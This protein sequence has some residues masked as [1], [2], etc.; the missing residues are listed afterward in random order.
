MTSFKCR[1]QVLG[2]HV[3]VQI[4]ARKADLGTW[5]SC[6]SLA[7]RPDEFQTFQK[8][9]PWPFEESLALR[10]PTGERDG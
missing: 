2:G 8:T 5:A 7:F 6:G 9:F 4:F 1:W 3:H 10:Q